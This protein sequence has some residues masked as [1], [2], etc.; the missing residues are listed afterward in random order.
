MRQLLRAG[1][2]SSHLGGAPNLRI[3]YIGKLLDRGRVDG[4]PP[5][6][7]FP[8]V[9]DWR[10]VPKVNL[11]PS[12]PGGSS[13]VSLLRLLL[14]VVL[15]VEGFFFQDWRGTN[16]A[17]AIELESSRIALQGAEQQLAQ[18]RGSADTIRAQLSQLQVQRNNQEREFQE[19]S[20][21]QID[22]APVIA[23]LFAAETDET[24]FQSLVASPDGEVILEGLA[25]GADAITALQTKLAEV[26]GVLDLQSIQSAQRGD[27]PSFTAN[28]RVRQP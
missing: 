11:L 4:R 22:W 10:K 3:P 2:N 20:A 14:M 23:A 6:S 18:Q 26:S 24:S 15:L 8:K 27:Q 19:V 21:G 9:R 17:V 16:G 28:F 25:T 5:K 13:P 1:G 12:R 7:A